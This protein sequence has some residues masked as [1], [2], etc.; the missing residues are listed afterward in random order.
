MTVSVLL[1]ARYREAAGAPSIDVEVGPGATIAEVW[2][3][4]RI[5]VPA[6][7]DEARPLFS[8]DRAYVRPDRIL[9]GREEIAVFPHVSGG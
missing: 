4:V 6:L 7:K 1:F 5:R 2:E 3:Q 8:C 9:S